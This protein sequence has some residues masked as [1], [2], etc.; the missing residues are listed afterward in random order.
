[1]EDVRIARRMILINAIVAGCVCAASTL[2]ICAAEDGVGHALPGAIGA[3]V[4]GAVLL[5]ALTVFPAMRFD[6]AVEGLASDFRSVSES[7][8]REGEFPRRSVLDGLSVSAA[9][10]IDALREQLSLART[11]IRELEI[12]Q[13]LTEAERA[14]A[15]AVLNSLRDAVLVTDA[16]NELAMANGQAASL[17]GFDAEQ[18]L[19]RPLDEIVSDETLRRM[20]Q[21]ARELAT[22][23]HRKHAEYTASAEPSDGDAG[24]AGPRCFDVT[25]SCLPD[26]KKGVGGVVTILRDVTHEREIAQMKSDFVSKVSHELRTPLSSINAYVELLLDGE[27]TDEDARQEFYQ[28]IKNE[29]DRLNRLIDN[30]LNISRIEAGIIKIERTEVDF[31]DVAQAAIDVIQPQAKQKDISLTLMKSPLACTAIADAD[32]LK[33]IMLNLMSNAVKYT[34]EG[35]R[36]TVTVENDDATGSVMVTVADT[37]LGIPPD[38]L[39]KVFD[40]FYRIENYKRVAKGTGLGLALCKHIVETVHGGQI[41]VTSELG[42]GSKFTFTIPYD[43]DSAVRA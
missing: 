19:R 25:L 35:G 34:P 5:A 17:L 22:P 8:E 27:A 31:A 9:D 23:A 26:P 20:I 30:M 15:E 16:F 7:P 6:R 42:M 41:S 32:M 40:K 2:A 33:Q 29:A 18:A 4:G 37:G 43:V 36:V 12:H 21:E 28:I 13:H 3:G 10:A 24:G 38:D 1:V 14:Q 39:P 11:R